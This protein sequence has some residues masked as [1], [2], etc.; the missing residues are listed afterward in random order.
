[1][2][3]I[4]VLNAHLAAGIAAL[5]SALVAMAFEPKSPA[6]SRKIAL[7]GVVATLF[8]FGA[9]LVQFDLGTPI[10]PREFVV[11]SGG[12]HPVGAATNSGVNSMVGSAGSG[13]S[14]AVTA[15]PTEPIFDWLG[16]AMFSYLGFIGARMIMA[17]MK[18]LKLR[19][20][21]RDFQ[22]VGRFRG[23]PFGFGAVASPC[24]IGVA[25]PRIFLPRDFGQLPAE[26]QLAVLHH[27]CVHVANRHC[28][29]LALREVLRI[30]LGWFWPVRTLLNAH[31][32]ALEA[33]CDLGSAKELGEGVSLARALVHFSS[34]S[35]QSAVCGLALVNAGTSLER[36]IHRL[37]S[38][39]K[40]MNINI[41]TQITI[42][43][44][45]LAGAAVASQTL[46]VKAPVDV[47]AAAKE[48]AKLANLEV[49][50]QWTYEY[51]W[52]GVKPNRFDLTAAKAIP[53]ADGVV[54]ELKNHSTSFNGTPMLSYSYMRINKDGVGETP[55]ATASNANPGFTLTSA[56]PQIPSE[57]KP[58]KK[59]SWGANGGVNSG[60]SS[61][62]LFTGEVLPSQQVMTPIGKRTATVIAIT[63]K[64]QWD[65]TTRT[66]YYVAGIGKVREELR[67]KDQLVQLLELKD[68]KPS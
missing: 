10:A 60:P 5:I 13:V 32:R 67:R 9:A 27:E 43:T 50:R 42:A 65:V 20:L 18:L 34:C 28:V 17:S 11:Q 3:I 21:M 33:E 22:F 57:L 36:R 40:T 24:V 68:Y 61:P 38:E 12:G 30:P 56:G 44:G 51:S 8:V 6:L 16:A 47:P 2:T 64:V 29:D 52:P 39:R 1:M 58:G 25:S 14:P 35:R 66:S 4:T 7:G 41:L 37:L 23:V 63:E 15:L 45:V 55:G 19:A 48:A 59:W 46:Q 54:Y 31:D 62:S 26:Q 53:V 49:G